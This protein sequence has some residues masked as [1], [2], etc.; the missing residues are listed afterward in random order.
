[1]ATDLRL[2]EKLEKY[3]DGLQSSTGCGIQFQFKC[4]YNSGVWQALID[5]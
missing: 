5:I 3:R 2:P 4:T 1:M